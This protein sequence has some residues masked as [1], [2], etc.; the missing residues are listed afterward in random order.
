MKW[1]TVWKFTDHIRQVVAMALWFF[2][3]LSATHYMLK[4]T[5][6]GPANVMFYLGIAVVMTAMIASPRAKAW[7][8]RRDRK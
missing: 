1:I 2:I 7:A 3:W 5:G 6:A 4:A 8:E